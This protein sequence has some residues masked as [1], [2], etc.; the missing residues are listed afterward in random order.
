VRVS[1]YYGYR[2]E[3]R[4]RA[5]LAP[6]GTQVES[7]GND[8]LSQ[9][10]G[11]SFTLSGNSLGA[12]VGGYLAGYDTSGDWYGLGN[13]ASGTQVGVTVRLPSTSGLVPTLALFKADGTQVTPDEVTATRLVY[14]LKAGDESTYYVRV[15]GS[16]GLG[17]MAE[18]FADIAI[19]DTVPPT[20]TSNSLPAEGTTVSYLAPSFTLGFSEDMLAASVNDL[21][22]YELVGSGG[23]GT[24]S[25][26]N[27]VVY[28]LRAPGYTSGLSASYFVTDGPLQPDSY[29]FTV[30]TVLKDKLDNSLA[31]PHV[32]NFTV[33][34]V[35]GY[36]SEDRDNGS[37]ATADTV[38][39]GVLA[40]GDGSFLDAGRTV[41]TAGWPFDI[42][43]ADLDGDGR[44]D[45]AVT[46]LGSVDG[47][48]IYPGNGTRGFGTPVVFDGIADEPYDV[49]LVDWDKDGD[50]DLAVT[51][52]GTDKV[53]LFRNDSTPGNPVFVRQ[54]DV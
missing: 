47:L 50:M 49:Q 43:T 40:Q 12:T 26:G 29:R 41:A 15:G 22:S 3:Y 18:Y 7:E 5:S 6:V 17:L 13:L 27:E 8:Q 44:T 20:I 2:G 32:R 10:D 31:A 1:P 14:T 51:L 11:V 52:A 39:T 48:R 45:A 25:D 33:T 54:A 36:V 23:D 24:F 16:S 53:G 38:S 9:A 35:P 19:S 30:G 4:F 42:E 34:G 21:A 28:H 46:H 37:I